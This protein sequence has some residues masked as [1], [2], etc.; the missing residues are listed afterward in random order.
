M[1]KLSAKAVDEILEKGRIY[2][3]GGAVR[4][5]M[6]SLKSPVKD[7]DYLV[8]GIGYDDLT[9]IRGLGPKLAHELNKL[10]IFRYEQIA[11]LDEDALSSTSHVLYSHKGRILRDGWIQQAAELAS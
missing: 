1:C 4:D 2:E 5:R 11:N 8:T 3:V 7:R 9:R 10:G 6:L